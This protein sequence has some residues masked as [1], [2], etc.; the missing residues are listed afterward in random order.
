M[1]AGVVSAQ[2]QDP[3]AGK[4][5]D[6]L[7]TQAKSYTSVKA[8]F[9]ARIMNKEDGL[10]IEQKGMVL[11]KGDRYRIESEGSIIICDGKALYVIMPEDGVG[12]INDLPDA[13][14]YG[15]DPSNLYDI[16]KEEFKYKLAK[17]D[18]SKAIINLFPKRPGE[19]PFHTVVLEVDTE[20]N[21]I[22]K[23]TVKG[24]E[25]NVYEYSIK[26]F[27]PNIEISDKKLRFSKADWAEVDDWT[28]LREE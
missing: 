23:A 28:D 1:S 5:L 27:T 18:G 22:K 8:E 7:S 13:D 6:A 11:V 3:K 19:A 25:G 17:E 21:Q 4:I 16:H 26:S 20:K 15:I 14:E 2:E 12:T 24:R 10:D 9:N